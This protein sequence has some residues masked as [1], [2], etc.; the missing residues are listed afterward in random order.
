VS[1]QAGAFERYVALGDSTTEGLMDPDPWGG[2]RHRGWADRLAEK[3]AAVNPGLHYANLAIRGRKLAQIRAEQLGP[4]LAKKPDLASVLAGVNDILRP[5]VDL[6]ARAEDLEAIVAALRASGATVLV[7]NY[8]DIAGSISFGSAR[9][10][11]V[12]RGFNRTIAAITERHDALLLDLESDEVKH[13]AMWSPDRL[14]AS[15]FGHERIADLAAATLGISELDPDWERRLP[16][17]S[18]PTTSRRIARDAYWA[19][20]YLAPWLVR[21]LRG[22][23]SGDGIEP[24]RPLPAPVERPGNPQAS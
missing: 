18:P 7:V 15:P 23:S 10:E 13:P 2:E 6:D 12:L 16:P 24:K 4:A 17:H 11:P 3:L 14:H 8:P 9:Y 20:R 22:V 5:K 19:G 1:S 21:R